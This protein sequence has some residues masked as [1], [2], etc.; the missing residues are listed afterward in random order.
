MCMLYGRLGLL[1][2]LWSSR[3][4]D[5]VCACEPHTLMSSLIHRGQERTCPPSPPPHLDQSCSETQSQ[6]E[7]WPANHSNS[8]VVTAVPQSCRQ[9]RSNLTFLYYQNLIA[10]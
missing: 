3:N 2:L 9:N 6:T 7:R 8:S 10:Y 4:R 5:C 1:L